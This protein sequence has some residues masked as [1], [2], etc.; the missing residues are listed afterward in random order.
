MAAGNMIVTLVAQT[1]KWSSGLQKAGRDT[2]TFGTI[3]Q[4]GFALGA[5][6]LVSLTYSLARAIPMLAQ[7]G[8]ESRKADIQLRFMIENMDG[9][10]AATEAAVAQMD[11]YAKRVSIATGIDDEQ[12]KAVQKKMLMFK[13]LRKTADQMGGSFDR[14]T[15]AAIDLAAGGFGS[16]ETNAIKLG[17]MLESPTSNLNALSR[18]GVVFTDQEKRK[19]QVLADSGRKLEAQDYILGKIEGRVKG[20]AE[21]SST[22]FERMTQQFRE[23]GDKIGTAMLPNLEQMNKKLGKWLHSRQGK[24]DLKDIIQGFV[25]ISGAIK[26]GAHYLGKFF[27]ALKN[28]KNFLNTP[29]DQLGNF[30]KPNGYNTHQGGGG[31]GGVGGG[32]STQP[33]PLLTPIINFN[34]PIDSVSAGR[35]V[36]RVLADYQRAAGRRV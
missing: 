16:M 7:M 31:G 4:R 9:A 33:S 23:M 32:R 34:A 8:S 22:P 2:T 35:E 24:Q 30:F 19:I 13:S 20:L 10:G 14:A 29:L 11:R 18:A 15:K 26:D 12:I 5:A 1:K 21:A 17:K 6:A 27:G 3:A 25:D 36:S 28:I